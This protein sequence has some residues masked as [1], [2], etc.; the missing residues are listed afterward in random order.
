[1]KRFNLVLILIIFQNYIVEGQ[2]ISNRQKKILEED[3]AKLK[4]T[5]FYQKF[6]NCKKNIE[7]QVASFYI[8]KTSFKAEDIDD[9]HRNY[10]AS[11]R[12]FNKILDELLFDFSNND[13]REIC[14]MYPDQYSKLLN[15]EIEDVLRFYKNNCLIK[16]EN[17]M[18]ESGS[19]GLMEIQMKIGLGGEII[20][21]IDLYK[22]H[23]KRMNAEFLKKHLINDLR[24]KKWEEY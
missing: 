24:L 5:E 12:E 8:K 15:A 6:L 21:M 1:M 7:S 2:V 19:F 4:K 9:V 16:I 22:K 20:K 13:R 23:S 11:S 17:L 3:I 18:Q 10:D 14:I